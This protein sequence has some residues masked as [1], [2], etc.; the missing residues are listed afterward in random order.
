MRVIV[1]DAVLGRVAAET[2]VDGTPVRIELGWEGAEE[3]H[4]SPIPSRISS[5]IAAALDGRGTQASHSAPGTPYQQRV[6]KVLS[7]V[8]V[9]ETVTYAELAR[10]AGGGPRSVAGACAAN[11]LALLIPCH[12]AVPSSGGTGGY[13]WGERAKRI[14]LEREAAWAASMTDQATERPRSA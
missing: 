14:L 3:I 13:R 10:R 5:E 8:P 7:E 4:G 12:R 2:N 1:D 11:P 9:G 6:W